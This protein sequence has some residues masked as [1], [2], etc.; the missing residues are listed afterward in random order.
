MAVLLSPLEFPVTAQNFN[1]ACAVFAFV[2][3]AGAVSWWVVPEDHWLSRRAV[4]RILD[5]TEGSRPHPAD[6]TPTSAP[7]QVKKESEVDAATAH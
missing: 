7:A 5:S 2:T 6:A 1:F 3:L 4:G